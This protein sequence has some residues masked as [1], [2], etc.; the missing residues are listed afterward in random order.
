M[1]LTPQIPQRPPVSGTAQP[2][3]QKATHHLQVDIS[4][5]PVS[6]LLNLHA[7]IEQALPAR[8]LKEV[9]LEKTLVFQLLA[10]QDLQRTV[11]EAGGD[12]EA[13]PT[14]KAQVMNTA[15]GIIATLSK[16]QIELINSERFKDIEAALIDT[17]NKHMTDEQARAFFIE[18]R[19]R[20]GMDVE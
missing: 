13:T 3:A 9:S 16:L 5:M 6:E 17:V 20:L 19:R 10:A 15:S 14:Q 1:T 12:D 11:L 8:S 2:E 4:G 7:R 18:Y